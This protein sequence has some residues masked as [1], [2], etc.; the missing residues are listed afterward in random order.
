MKLLIL[1]QKIDK[2]DDLLGFFYAWV[3]EFAKYY[4]KITVICLYRGESDLPE[5]VKVLSLG[6]EN[7]SSRE[8]PDKGR[9]VSLFY[10]FTVKLLYILNFYRYIW[11]ERKNYDRVFIHMNPEYGVLGGWVWKL[12]GKKMVMWY[13]H[14]AVNLKL[15]I[16]EKFVSTVFTA[17]AD[18]FQLNSK[19]ARVVGHGVDVD[20]FAGRPPEADQPKYN[21]KLMAENSVL[22]VGRISKIK[23]Q[24]LL[25]RAADYLVNKKD[26]WNFKF[27]FIGEPVYDRDKKYFEEIKRF[28]KDKKI[29]EY[30]EFSGKVSHNN[31]PREYQNADLLV[32]LCPTGGMD[33]AV[34]EAMSCERGVIAFNKTFEKLLGKYQ[35]ELILSNEDPE[36][37]GEKIN[38]FLNKSEEEKKSIGKNLREEII[39]NHSMEKLIKNLVAYI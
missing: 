9:Y 7:L 8:V 10:C 33:K 25:V 1:T 16:A 27:N 18:S 34:L 23:N 6:K 5:N 36:E 21:E 38:K 30:I 12:M 29:Q 22:Y 31:M 28:I 15:R 37:L 17:S 20:K 4:K 11:Q 13:T 32:N 26:I 14:K 2:N 24:M 39:E 3:G 19:K 35:E